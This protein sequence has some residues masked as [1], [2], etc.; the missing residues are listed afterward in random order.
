MI[1]IAVVNACTCLTDAQIEQAVAALQIQVSRDFAP[2]W[3]VDAQ[4]TFFPKGQTP[5]LGQSQL[6]VMDTSD[7]AQALGHHDLTADGF[8]IGKSFAKSDLD[9]GYSWT[10]T[11]SHELLEMI[12]DPSINLIAEIDNADGTSLFIAYEIAD[13]VESDAAGY[14]IDGIR[15]SNFVLPSYFE[16]F[17]KPGTKYDFCGLLRGPAPAMLPDGYLSI[18][19]PQKGWQQRNAEHVAGRSVAVQRPRVGSRRERRRTPRSQ[20]IRSSPKQDGQP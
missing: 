9:G 15:V 13:P 4:L 18:L 1:Q 20:W 16:S 3:G 14:D 2:A 11:L 6:I 10:V 17:H 12:A 7:D 5:P 19:D 8:P